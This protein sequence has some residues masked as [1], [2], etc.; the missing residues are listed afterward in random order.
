MEARIESSEFL[1]LREREV[2]LEASAPP[3]E[4]PN[5]YRRPGLL[6]RLKER[7]ER[8]EG[9]LARPDLV[10]VTS[11]A[12]L[13]LVS[14][15][16]GGDFLE[17]V[18]SKFAG[19]A[20][21]FSSQACLGLYAGMLDFYASS[22]RS[23]LILLLESPADYPQYCLDAVGAG[24]GGDEL[25]ARDAC[26]FAFFEK[27]H[28]DE[29]KDDDLLVESC[30][31]FT[32][33]AGLTGT[34]N[35]VREIAATMRAFQGRG[36][37]KTVSFAIHSRWSNQILKAFARRLPAALGPETWLDSSEPERAHFLSL[38]PIL[39][40][41]RYQDRL[42]EAFLFI[43]TLGAAGRFGSLLVS[44]YGAM[45]RRKTDHPLSGPI[46][47]PE[48]REVRARGF[49]FD[50]DIAR[51]RAADRDFAGNGDIKGLLRK[52]GTDLKYPQP[53]FRRHNEFFQWVIQL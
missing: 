9:A 39:E 51:A 29:L 52:I 41:N 25:S 11:S 21:H 49:S 17:F 46:R 5:G 33:A 23:M 14:G 48:R 50:E 44:R 40:L 8:L 7:L 4:G 36:S 24:A 6:A 15:P 1:V 38:K 10:V 31:I 43:P 27:R 3:V 32:Q 30:S 53:D 16:E 34:T 20:L 19:A 26:G 35:L 2:F 37:L 42:E 47:M 22:H 28:R 45:P 18:R 12:E 13:Y